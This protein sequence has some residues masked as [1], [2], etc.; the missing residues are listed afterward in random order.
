MNIESSNRGEK[1]I[2]LRGK[3]VSVEK[4]RL[5]G[6]KGYL[7]TEVDNLMKKAIAEKH[8]ER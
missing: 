8:L 6:K 2:N 7:V 4:E 1:M 5:A 3:L